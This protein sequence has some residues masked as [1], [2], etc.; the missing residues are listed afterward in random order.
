MGTSITSHV[1][2]LGAL[3]GWLWGCGDPA[4]AQSI[5]TVAGGGTGDG[6]PA[7]SAY[8]RSPA[9]ICVDSEGNLL[10]AERTPTGS[11]AWIS[12]GRSPPWPAAGP[13]AAGSATG[14]RP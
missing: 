13:P 11:A 1:A 5:T 6:V 9:G 8:L 3:S 10:I 14:A 4:Q 7:T 2:L 12:M